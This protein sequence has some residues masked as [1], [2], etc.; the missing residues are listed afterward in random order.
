M[1]FKKYFLIICCALA[2]MAGACKKKKNDDGT[3][4]TPPAQ[5]AEL[6]VTIPN[7]NLNQDNNAAQ[8]N[9]LGVTVNVTSTPLPP[10]GYTITITATNPAG[11]V[12][13]QNAAVTGTGG[14]TDITLIN[15]P[16]LQVAKIVVTITSNTK[17]SNTKTFRFGVMNKVP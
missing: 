2:V 16:S 12:I 1:P 5:E 6:A 3:P 15:L 13:A 11:E 14:S 8:G 4:V 9:T 7:I 17:P 10:E